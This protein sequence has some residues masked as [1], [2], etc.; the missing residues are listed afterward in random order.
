MLQNSILDFYAHNLI[1][2]KDLIRIRQT[3]EE[4]DEN[5]DGLLSYEEIEIVMTR[6]GRQAET[7]KIFKILD[8]QHTKDISYEEFIKSL[9]DRKQLEVQKNIRRC[10]DAID[11]DGNG[12]ISIDEL[13]KISYINN[14]PT[15]EKQFKKTFYQYSNGK[16]YVRLISSIM[17]IF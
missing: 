5:G 13:K 14:D 1:E 10:F 4:F 7:K 9:M 17:K 15:K 12:H 3:F 8:Y 2:K 6:M 16:H 11:D